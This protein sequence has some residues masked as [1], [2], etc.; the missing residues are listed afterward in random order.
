[1]GCFFKIT[2][3]LAQVPSRPRIYW[4]GAE[5]K[6]PLTDPSAPLT[7]F[8]VRLVT[9]PPNALPSWW[10]V[11]IVTQHANHPERDA[12]MAWKKNY[13][14]VR[15]ASW[16]WY[17]MAALCFV[18]AVTSVHDNGGQFGTSFFMWVAGATGLAFSAGRSKRKAA[19][20]AGA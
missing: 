5:G 11:A 1:M 18:Q 12:K 16:I 3:Q 13:S 14:T 19:A 4:A 6:S 10:V 8:L 9:V 2:P 15:N 7:E 17:L 20:K